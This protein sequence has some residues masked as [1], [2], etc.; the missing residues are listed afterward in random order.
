MSVANAVVVM[1]LEL[2]EVTRI[3]H[4]NKIK[5]QMCVDI[6]IMKITRGDKRNKNTHKLI[7]IYFMFIILPIFL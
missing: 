3:W 2:E 7:L 4:Q 5:I 1:I 6:N